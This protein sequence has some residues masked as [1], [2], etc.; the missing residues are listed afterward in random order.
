MTN[1]LTTIATVD[2]E[3]A[4]GGRDPIPRRAPLVRGPAAFLGV[5][6]E[7]LQAGANAAVAAFHGVRA[8]IQA[9]RKPYAPQNVQNVMSGLWVRHTGQPP[10]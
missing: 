5:R 2:L 10:F 7:A 1:D 4:A 9:L 3:R 8:S 6:A